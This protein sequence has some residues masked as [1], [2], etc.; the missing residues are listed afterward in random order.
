MAYPT[1]DQLKV[2]VQMN[3]IWENHV[4]LANVDLIKKVYGKDNTS[5]PNYS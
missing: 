2:M 1:I 5:C 3:L 4:T